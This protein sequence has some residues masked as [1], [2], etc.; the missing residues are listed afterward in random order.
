MPAPKLP[1]DLIKKLRKLAEQ[2]EQDHRTGPYTESTVGSRVGHANRFID[3]LEGRYDPKTDF[4]KR[5]V[6]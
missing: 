2:Y 3:Y 1:A 6:P 4:R 5:I